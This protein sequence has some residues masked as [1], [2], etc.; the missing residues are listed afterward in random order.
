GIE[1]P[2]GGVTRFAGQQLSLGAGE[3]PRGVA[4][5]QPTVRSLEGRLVLDELIGA[6]LALGISSLAS[7]RAQA[8]EALERVGARH[9]EGRR[10]CELD[11]AEEVRVAIARALLQDP[12]LLLIDEPIKGV[13][14]LERD[15]ILDLLHALSR[16]GVSVLMTLDRGVGLFGADRALSLGEGRLRGPL[17]PEL[18]EVVALHQRASG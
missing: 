4:Y 16:Q 11:R 6:Q 13:D 1:A 10:P 17:V 5:C 2:D 18:A 8:W 14:A 7:A 15:K 12:C 9:C 3:I